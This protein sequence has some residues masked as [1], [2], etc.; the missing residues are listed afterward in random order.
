[1]LL[2]S[3]LLIAMNFRAPITGVAPILTQLQEAFA[4]TPAQAGLLTTLPL[5][6]FGIVS[7]FASL[8]ARAY[9]LERT[10]FASLLLIAAGIVLR[11]T[12]AAWSL[13][14]GT[15]ILGTGIAL[16]NVLL[17]GLLKREFPHR[18][19]R[20]TGACALSMGIAAAAMS[21]GAV[22]LAVAAG[23]QAALGASVL[24]PLVAGTAWLSQLSSRTAPAAV[25]AAPQ[26][27]PVWRSALAWQVTL[28][29]GTNSLLYYVVVA[30]LPTMPTSAGVPADMA[31][32]LHGVMQL[33]TAVPGLLLGTLL[34]RMKDQKLVAAAMS[35]LLGLSLA[36]FALWPMAASLWAACFGFASGG[37]FILALVFMGLRTTSPQQAASLSGM[38]QCAGYLLAAGGPTLAGALHDWAGNWSTV[39]WIGALL[40]L[41]MAACG[42]LAG[43]ARTIGMAGVPA[44]A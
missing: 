22:P 19:A 34:G 15:I 27:G 38:A 21:A 29:I 18:I 7:P 24:L 30:W 9:G 8:L 16:G 26:G 5:L 41:L 35:A 42:V 39:L 14:A 20:L 3:L 6:A 11:S 31:G 40:S 1:M 36:G 33:A 2:A 28:F 17:P 32:S 23:W 10:L 37:V 43:R 12:G 44:T 4:L 25:A 13:F